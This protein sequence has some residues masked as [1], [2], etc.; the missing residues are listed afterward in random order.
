MLPF[1]LYIPENIYWFSVFSGI[2]GKY[3]DK[4]DS[5]V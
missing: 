3:W 4:M 5:H 1:Y 2:E